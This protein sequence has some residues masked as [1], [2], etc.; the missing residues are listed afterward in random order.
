M[1]EPEEGPDFEVWNHLNSGWQQAHDDIARCLE[2]GQ[3]QL[4]ELVASIIV[5]G[6]S[7]LH[8]DSELGPVRE[9]LEEFIPGLASSQYEV[10]F[11]SFIEMY[12]SGDNP[13][14]KH[15]VELELARAGVW[16]STDAFD[17]FALLVPQLSQR[18]LP[19]RAEPYLRE[20]IQTFLFGFDPACIALCRSALEQV[21]R[22]VLVRLGE[23]TE[24][25]LRRDQP[26]LETL[27]RKLQ[28]RDAIEAAADA[29]H[30]IRERG[31]TVLHHHLY[32]NRARRQVALDSLV[33]LT[34]VLREA[35]P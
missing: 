26:S 33:D 19:A 16:R 24:P 20:A 32:E 4:F 10:V 18:P 35:L 11:N 12:R 25:Q 34:I 29:A 6:T 27:L 13:W 2:P 14:L 23:Y 3:M 21:A 7:A 31:N 30:R 28:Q 1:T 9:K 22:D 8:L 5:G 17:R 15:A